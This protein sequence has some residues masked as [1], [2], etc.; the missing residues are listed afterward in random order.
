MNKTTAS[1][2]FLRLRQL[3]YEHSDGAAGKAPVFGLL[4]YRGKVYAVV[5]PNAKATRVLPIIREKEKPYSIL[6]T[7]GFK[8]YN[9]LDLSEFKHD[10]MNLSEHFVEQP[11]HMNGIENV[12]NQAKRH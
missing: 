12:W 11:N 7:D 9:A 2:Y 10:R 5:I 1:D 8:G 6:Y 3:I 4:K